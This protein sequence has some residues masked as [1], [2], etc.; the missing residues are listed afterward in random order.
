[1]EGVEQFESICIGVDNCFWTFRR[2][3]ERERAPKILEVTEK[4]EPPLSWKQGAGG[5][6]VAWCKK[7]EPIWQANSQIFT[8]RLC[9]YY[10]CLSSTSEKKKRRGLDEWSEPSPLGSNMCQSWFKHSQLHLTES[11]AI[12]SYVGGRWCRSVHSMTSYRYLRRRLWRSAFD[13]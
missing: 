3:N 5:K 4:Q 1:M 2:K 11:Y 9:N 12:K 7:H 8:T 6:V 10:M 13:G